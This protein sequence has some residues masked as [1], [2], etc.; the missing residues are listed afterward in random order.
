M[1]DFQKAFSDAKKDLDNNNLFLLLL[2]ASGN[3]KSYVQGTFGCKV[4]YL[5]TKGEDHGPKSASRSAE[6]GGLGTSIVPVRIDHDGSKDLNADESLARL[7]NILDD[8]AGIKAAGFGALVLD[9][10]TELEHLVR[11]SKKFIAMTT[12]DAGKHNSFAEGGATLF[13]F[14]E[15]IGKLKKLH[16]EAK[17]HICATEILT[18]KELNDEGLILDSS[19]QLLG[20]A[21]ATGV[22]QQFDDVIII[23]K[24][25]KKD[26]IAYRFQLIAESGKVSKDA[27][28]K[29]VKKTF[30]F[31]PRLTG[32]DILALPP[33]IDAN[34]TDLI[35]LKQGAKK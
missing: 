29:E 11:S 18:I 13:Q 34:L 10:F 28:T 23:G 16:K 4:L 7:H 35:K 33:T 2:G 1:F 30:N 17:I 27:I 20:Y 15:I 5:Y 25:S 8:V 21:V 32:V 12:T 31:S 26:K 22:V 3:G 19:P 14:K 6:A 24:M 9:S